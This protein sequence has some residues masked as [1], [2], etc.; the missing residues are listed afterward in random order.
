MTRDW[1]YTPANNGGHTRAATAPNRRVHGLPCPWIFHCCSGLMEELKRTQTVLH[2]SSFRLVAVALVVESCPYRLSVGYMGQPPGCTL[3]SCGCESLISMTK[4][5]ESTY[6]Y[7]DHMSSLQCVT[8]G[9]PPTQERGQRLPTCTRLGLG[10]SLDAQYQYWIH[11]SRRG[12]WTSFY[13]TLAVTHSQISLGP[14]PL[15][16][17]IRFMSS[18][19][20]KLGTQD[21]RNFGLTGSV[22]FFCDVW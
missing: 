7:T 9:Q 15:L 10:I 14:F 5:P 8:Y 22:W 3:R 13:V 11:T 21:H 12:V 1:R 2:T 4:S 6:V 19:V 20:K 18:F 16:S 17:K